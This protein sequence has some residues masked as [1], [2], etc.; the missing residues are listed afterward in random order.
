[1]INFCINDLYKIYLH[2]I[3]TLMCAK[4][5]AQD[6]YALLTAATLNG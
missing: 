4:N 5:S 6:G 2:V 3:N 1:M